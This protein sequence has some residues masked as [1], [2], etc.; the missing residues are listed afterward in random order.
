MR[1]DMHFPVESVIY[2]HE[3]ARSFF[4]VS[5]VNS[6]WDSLFNTVKL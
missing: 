3:N 6:A 4:S 2:H 1:D 5:Q